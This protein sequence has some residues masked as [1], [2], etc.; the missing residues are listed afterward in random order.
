MIEITFEAGVAD[1][2]AAGADAADVD[3]AADDEDV[4]VGLRYLFA[5]AVGSAPL[6]PPPPPHAVRRAEETRRVANVVTGR[7]DFNFIT[8]LKLRKAARRR[9]S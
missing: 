6:P 2:A 9:Y 4:E 8:N 1:D 7:L 3:D 5:V